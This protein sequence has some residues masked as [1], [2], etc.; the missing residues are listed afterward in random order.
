MNGT[1]P[2]DDVEVVG[3]TEAVRAWKP[4]GVRMRDRRKEKE[5]TN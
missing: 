3:L 2:H 1:Q 5:V 4:R